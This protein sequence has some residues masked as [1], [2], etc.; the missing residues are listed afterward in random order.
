MLDAGMCVVRLNTAHGD[1]DVSNATLWNIL[2]YAQVP[3]SDLLTKNIQFHQSI[4]DNT[5]KACEKRGTLCA[6]LIDIK[7]PQHGCIHQAKTF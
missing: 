5:R 4:I 2:R 3:L 1:F 7:V 6:I